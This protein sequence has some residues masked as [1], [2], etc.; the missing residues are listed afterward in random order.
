MPLHLLHD[1]WLPVRDCAGMRHWIAPDRLSDPAF[2]AFDAARGD[3]NGVLAQFAIGLLQ[4]TS[5]IED[6]LDWDEWLTRSP[7]AATL[8]QWFAPVADAFVLDGDGARFMQDFAL[9]DEGVAVNGIGTLL[10]EAPGE[11]TARNNAD[12]FVKS[13][14]VTALCPACAATALLTLQLNAPAGGAGHRTGLRGGGPLT[15]LVLDQ[16]PGSLWR[17]LWLN[18]FER[19]DFLAGSGDPDRTAR[20]AMF[21]W[22]GPITGLQ[23]A[24]GQLTPTQVHPAHVHWAMPRRI[25]LDFSTPIEGECSICARASSGLVRQYATRNYGLNYK[26]AWEHPF[27]PYYQVKDD[28]LPVHPQPGGFGWRHW[29]GWV[30]GNRD[31]KKAQRSARV[32]GHALAAPRARRL[33]GTLRLWAFGYDMDNMKARCWYESTVPL[34]GLADC[35]AEAQSQIRAEVTRWLAGA[36][37]AASYLRLAIRNAWFGAEVR[38]DLSVVDA[39][40]WSGTEDAF[41]MRLQRL[42]ETLRSGQPWAEQAEREGWRQVLRGKA[43]ALFDRTFVGSGPVER[44]RPERAAQA[45]QRLRA[46]LHGPKL[47]DALGLPQPVGAKTGKP[48]KKSKKTPKAGN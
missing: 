10:I 7:N 24:G 18:V 2:V 35:G 36:E 6:S 42:I 21:P 27:S 45:W 13:G 8:R 31:D 11:N 9:G 33:G 23:P 28:W 48:A 26:G 5:P 14:H 43:L 40:F 29:L 32:V 25:R 15:T 44:Q 41:Y 34:Y 17:D 39:S 46:S 37:L 4:T 47:N 16:R 20:H 19:P 1:S 22:L 3:F 30:F 12:L 38:G